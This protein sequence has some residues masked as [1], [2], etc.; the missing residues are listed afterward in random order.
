[1]AWC[2]ST[3][4]SVA[5]VLTTHPCVSR[6]LRVKKKFIAPVTFTANKLNLV[7]ANDEPSEDCPNLLQ[8]LKYWGI[9]CELLG[10]HSSPSMNRYTE[11]SSSKCRPFGSGQTVSVA[12][13]CLMCYLF[14]HFSNPSCYH[15]LPTWSSVSRFI[16]VSIFVFTHTLRIYIWL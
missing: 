16:Y 2:F 14:I 8:N 3:R 5:T 4:A 12:R 11:T 7:M 10:V 9:F 6:C 1:M 13:G 15:N